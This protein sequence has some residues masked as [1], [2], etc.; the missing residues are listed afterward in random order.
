MLNNLTPR[1]LQ[2]VRLIVLGYSNTQ[3]ADSLCIA[4]P[5]AKAHVGS[6]LGKFG[7]KNRIQAAVIGAC[8]LK[9]KLEE[10]LE[11]AKTFDAKDEE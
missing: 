3:I 11:A 1:E 2:V 10:V 6:I 9:I 4:F 7:V 8:L 5:T